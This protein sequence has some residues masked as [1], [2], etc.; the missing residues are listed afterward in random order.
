MTPTGLKKA[1]VLGKGHLNQPARLHR[2]GREKLDSFKRQLT[3]T[4]LPCF[5]ISLV[6]PILLCSGQLFPDSELSF[7][8]ATA[9]ARPPLY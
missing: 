8:S 2:I 6:C 9:G 4:I 7:S 3:R 1:K 5:N